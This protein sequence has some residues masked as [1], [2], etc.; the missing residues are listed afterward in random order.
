MKQTPAGSSKSGR[1]VYYM[2]HL[3]AIWRRNQEYLN[4]RSRTADLH[5]PQE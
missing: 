1:P 2:E 4:R 3:E 5:S